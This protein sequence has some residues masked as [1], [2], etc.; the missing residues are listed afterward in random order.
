MWDIKREEE[1]GFFKEKSLSSE[2]CGI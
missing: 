2:P 1:K